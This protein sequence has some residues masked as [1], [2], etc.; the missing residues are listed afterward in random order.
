VASATAAEIPAPS[1]PES[2]LG[3]LN[4]SS[5]QPPGPCRRIATPTCRTSLSVRTRRPQASCAFRVRVSSSQ[6]LSSLRRFS[7]DGL[8]E[9]VVSMTDAPLGRRSSW[10]APYVPRVGTVSRENIQCL[11]W[12]HGSQPRKPILSSG[13]QQ[14]SDRSPMFACLH[15]PRFPNSRNEGCRAR[16]QRRY[17]L[18]A[19]THRNRFARCCVRR[20]R[21]KH[22]NLAG[23][24]RSRRHARLMSR[25]PGTR[26]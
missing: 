4:C 15:R 11:S 2:P 22:R 3:S 10:E 6:R 20:R 7:S 24:I 8:F 17:S 5:L 19:A 21:R 16:R 13:Q 18:R 26:S 9:G 12:P 1:D 23:E 14:T 25:P